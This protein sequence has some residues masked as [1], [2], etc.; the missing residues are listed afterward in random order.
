V[1]MYFIFI[2]VLLFCRGCGWCNIVR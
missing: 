2:P 1:D